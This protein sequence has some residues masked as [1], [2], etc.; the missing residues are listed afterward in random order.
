MST[1]GL[2]PLTLLRPYIRESHHDRTAP[3]PEAGDLIFL[4]LPYGLPIS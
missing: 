3:L 2:P 4:Q 1:T